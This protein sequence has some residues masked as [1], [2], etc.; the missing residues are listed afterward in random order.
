MAQRLLV[1]HDGTAA[2]T[3]ALT[4]AARMALAEH[5]CLTV[6]LAL[7]RVTSCVTGAP[8]SYMHLQH[9]VRLEALRTLA[10]AVEAMPRQ[11]SVTTVATERRLG[12]AL[13]D[14]WS[15]GRYDAI[16][17]AP[18]GAPMRRLA[19]LRLRLG[20]LPLTL[21]PQTE[22]DSRV[23]QGRRRRVAGAAVPPRSV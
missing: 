21:L 7:P 16:V 15:S 8:V 5:G 18:G 14:A 11:L 20:G 6:V 2:S 4:Q 3:H 17:L 9:E 22:A 1:G 10:Q 12:A 19:A 13:R 23:P